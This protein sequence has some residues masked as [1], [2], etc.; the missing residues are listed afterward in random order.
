MFLFPI[1]A[2]LVGVA[3]TTH[4]LVA[5]AVLLLSI[6]GLALAWM[7][8]A[9]LDTLRYRGRPV[10][11]RALLHVAICFFAVLGLCY[12]ALVRDNLLEMVI[13][14]VQFGPEP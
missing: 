10:R 4:Q 2:V 14:T 11:G 6:G 12:V 1:A 3:L 13:E 9:A 5:P 8:G 7:S